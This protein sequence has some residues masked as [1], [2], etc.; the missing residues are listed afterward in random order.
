M[1]RQNRTFARFPVRRQ[2]ETAITATSPPAMR[3]SRPWEKPVSHS[4][5]LAEQ[6]ALA[7]PANPVP[8]SI[9]NH[10]AC[11]HSGPRF[12]PFRLI[13]HQ[14]E[15]SPNTFQR[16]KSSPNLRA[17][18]PGAPRRDTLHC[19]TCPFS[20]RATTIRSPP[21]LPFPQSTHTSPGKPSIRSLN[22]SRK[23]PRQY[24]RPPPSLQNG[25]P[26]IAPLVRRSTFPHLCRCQRLHR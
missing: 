12:L 17:I 15:S 22:F 13:A 8:N 5:S 2:T 21:L 18:P 7:P 16:S 23:T 3:P 1:R 26:K 4:K 19:P 20:S 24:S 25:I 9:N 6:A 10:F 14:R 11:G